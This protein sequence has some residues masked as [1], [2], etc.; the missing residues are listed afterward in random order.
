MYVLGV[1]VGATKTEC[2]ITDEKES[3]MG[4]GFGGPGNYQVCGIEM[5]AASMKKAVFSALEEA[6]LS[7]EDITCA[8][9]PVRMERR[10]FRCLFLPYKKLWGK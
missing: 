4:R 9:F 7:L 6:R 1:D 2:A 8:V 10:I 3:I 5:A